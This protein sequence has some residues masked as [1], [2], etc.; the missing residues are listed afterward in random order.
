MTKWIYRAVGTV[1]VAAG[2]AL[3]LAG[4][5][6]QAD[7]MNSPVNDLRGSLDGFLTP[8]G[9]LQSAAPVDAA[10]GQHLGFLGAVPANPAAG[11]DPAALEAGP[12]PAPISADS[13]TL[14]GFG[15]KKLGVDTV[16][17]TVSS[18]GPLADNPTGV[19]GDD[20]LLKGQATTGSALPVV[21]G[22]PLGES[23]LGALGNDPLG[24][25]GSARGLTGALEDGVDQTGRTL[26][27][28]NLNTIGSDSQMRTLGSTVDADQLGGFGG[29][30]F[31]S[32]GGLDSLGRGGGLP[33]LGGAGGVGGL[34]GG[35]L[36]ELASD[37][38]GAVG[39]HA[40]PDPG[41]FGV[42]DLR[43][44]DL[45]GI[46]G[47]VPPLIGEALEAEM[48]PG[49]LG[50]LTEADDSVVG[51][52]VVGNL[53]LSGVDTKDS[54]LGD[55]QLLNSLGSFGGG[56]APAVGTAAPA[57]KP[58]QA[59]APARTQ[60]APSPTADDGGNTQRTHRQWSRSSSERPVDGEDADFR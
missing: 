9:D 27:D 57:P 10:P 2:G 7:P 5:A 24:L 31:D 46:G 21:G 53:P 41:D 25:G 60:P 19:L 23:P 20:Q 28:D 55:L 14:L 54:P 8:M 33:D 6:A 43:G 11:V 40:A 38:L 17:D 3:L 39:K 44:G 35:A 58:A 16:G 4:G 34:G 15:D 26:S 42:A 37:P 59:P 52:P 12:A 49:F 32:L 45:D 29:G 51:L 13:L 47:L 18:V 22:S 1:G 48:P 30:T 50:G 36:D 56:A